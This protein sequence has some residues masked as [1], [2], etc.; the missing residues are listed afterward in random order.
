MKRTTILMWYTNDTHDTLQT[1]QSVGSSKSGDMVLAPP[2]DAHMHRVK[3]HRDSLQ[4]S[5]SKRGSRYLRNTVPPS[6]MPSLTGAK[7]DAK[8][9]GCT[10]AAVLVQECIATC[11]KK[12][13]VHL[14]YNDLVISSH[15]TNQRCR[16]NGQRTTT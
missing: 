3:V 13:H 2:F 9:C 5:A 10:R 14:V 6:W 7:V 1:V 12:T 8:N 4:S 16:V 11:A 15:V